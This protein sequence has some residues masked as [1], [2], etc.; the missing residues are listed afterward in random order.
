MLVYTGR[1]KGKT[2][3]ALELALRASGHG[4]RVFMVQ[5][6]KNDPKYGEIQAIQKFLPD[7][8]VVQ[9]GQGVAADPRLPDAGGC[10]RGLERVSVGQG[11]FA[12]RQV[13][14]GDF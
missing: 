6:R 11:G 8:T 12:E 9:S 1:G 2:T 14:P 5:F 3:A 10:E 13:R 4:A 7:F